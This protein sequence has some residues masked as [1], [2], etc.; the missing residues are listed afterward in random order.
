MKINGH[1]YDGKTSKRFEAT[2]WV[3]DDLIEV[4]R[5]GEETL[6]YS[7]S[8][9]NV[10]GR[11]A[12]L[13][14][15][16][17]FFD[18]ALFETKE[19]E[20]VLKIHPHENWKK[21]LHAVEDRWTFIVPA[22]CFSA[23]VCYFIYQSLL[24]VMAEQMA[25]RLPDK[26]SEYMQ[27]STLTLLEREDFLKKTQL[28]SSD[29]EH[30]QKLFSEL[31]EDYKSINFELK[32]TA[33]EKMGPNAFALPAGRIYFTESLYELLKEDPGEIQAVLL[34]E[35]GHVVHKHALKAAVQQAGLYFFL[36]F[37]VGFGDWSTLS[38][39]LLSSS[40]SRD[41]EREA[42]SFAAKELEARALEPLLLG[43]ALEK[44]EDERKKKKKL[45]IPS[46]ISTHPGTDER[47]KSLKKQ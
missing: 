30:M 44:M 12:N 28:K 39:V 37:V 2:L 29:K 7:K 36:S 11:I 18:Q 1:F 17:R 21:L 40:Y 43:K 13:P 16:L 6:S 42:D 35:M 19:Y 5:E 38:L 45:E 33:T 26:V 10:E 34:H 4:H 20:K 3:K 22:L 9:V 27:D 46:W 32:M 47:I 14:Q 24:P 8:E 31:T 25:Q 41:M 23:M 15:T